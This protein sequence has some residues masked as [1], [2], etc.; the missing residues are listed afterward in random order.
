MLSDGRSA[1]QRRLLGPLGSGAPSGSRPLPRP[2]SGLRP[3]PVAQPTLVVREWLA[4]A[5]E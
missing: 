2:E 1:F 5:P 3:D 4:A